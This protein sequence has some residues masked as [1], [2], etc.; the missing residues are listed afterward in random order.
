MGIRLKQ[1]LA[2]DKLVRVFGLGQ[3]CDPKFIQIIGQQG[4]Y[5][6][7]WLDQEHAGISN[8]QIEHASLAARSVGLDSFVR[9]APTDYATVM[10]P[11]EAGAGGV[12]AAQVRSAAQAEDVLQWAKFY[13]RGLRGVNGSGVDG[14]FATMPMPDY[15]KKANDE[16][17]VA[18][19]IEHIGAVEEVEKIAALKDVDVL[20]IGPADLGQSMGIVGDWDHPK[21]W[22]AIERVAKAARDQRIHWAI[23][24]RNLPYAKRCV[25]L[26]CKMLSLGLDVWAIQRGL[27]AFLTEFESLG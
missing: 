13:P 7:V 19:Q 16:T 21:I 26:G 1:A 22:Q 8:G 25:D 20:F 27:K 12:M 10:R 3:I 15:L 24:P 2:G 9:L 4:G 17:F 18:I 6:A 23:L 5:D 11:L 14:R